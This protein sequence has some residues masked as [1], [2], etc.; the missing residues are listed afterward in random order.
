M[1]LGATCRYFIEVRMIDVR[2][3][4]EQTPHDSFDDLP[5]KDADK[6]RQEKRFFTYLDME[7]DMGMITEGL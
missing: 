7:E 2:V 4:A 1:S 5:T 3:D 6:T